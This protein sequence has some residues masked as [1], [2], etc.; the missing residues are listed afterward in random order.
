M[1]IIQKSI[2]SKENARDT[3][4]TPS[5]FGQLIT[6]FKRL[7]AFMVICSGISLFLISGIGQ[8]GDRLWLFDLASHFALQYFCITFVLISIAALLRLKWGVISLLPALLINGLILSPYL[9]TA[10]FFPL[11]SVVSASAA[12]NGTA[13]ST[14]RMM[15]A[16]LYYYNPETKMVYDSIMAAKPDILVLVEMGESNKERMRFLDQ[17]FAEKYQFSY[18]DTVI[19]ANIELNEVEVARITVESRPQT[20]FTFDLDGETVTTIAAHAYTPLRPSYYDARNIE[21]NRLAE[22]VE[23]LGGPIIVTGDLNISSFSPIFR[24]FAADGGLTDGRKGFGVY[25]SW[26]I[27]RPWFQIPIDHF[28]A[29]DEIEIKGFETGQPTGSDHLP[30]IVDF[31]VN[32]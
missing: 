24:R 11:T 28:L 30:I 27:F 13:Q 22:T 23:Q 9:P 26:N 20:I 12:S 32:R 3:R 4:S 7:V 8:L 31:S 14:I 16:N 10:Q 15:T 19:Y 2:D 29:T 1:A 25:P 18:S 5:I 21:L 6:W 17:Q